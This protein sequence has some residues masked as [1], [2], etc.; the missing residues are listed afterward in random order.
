MRNNY[1]KI[2]FVALLMV[3]L[4]TTVNTW[5]QEKVNM[6][7]TM[8]HKWDGVGADASYITTY[9]NDG[10]LLVLV[11]LPIRSL[12]HLV[13]SRRGFRLPRVDGS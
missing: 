1:N 10:F 12:S 13:R 11:L 8:F 3:M 9:E 5:A 7:Q 6:A 4:L 2:R